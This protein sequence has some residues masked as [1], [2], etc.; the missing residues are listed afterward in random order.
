MAGQL[1]LDDVEDHEGNVLRGRHHLVVPKNGNILVQMLVV[2]DVENMF[3]DDFLE[4]GDVHDHA[5][6]WVDG[7]LHC[8][9]HLV[10]VSMTVGVVAR[11]VH[12][13]VFCLP[14]LVAVES[15]GGAELLDPGNVADGGSHGG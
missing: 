3:V 8:H 13:G 15:V 7:A 5:G 2:H 14:K 6:D 12:L 11:A 1:G 9:L 10:V 4:V